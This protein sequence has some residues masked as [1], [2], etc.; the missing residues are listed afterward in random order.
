[1]NGGSFPPKLT[2]DLRFTRIYLSARKEIHEAPRPRCAP[3]C[4]RGTTACA[5]EQSYVGWVKR[6]VLFHGKR[7]P[8]EMGEAEIN[9]FLSSLATDG[10]VAASTQNQA[11]SAL[12][13]PLPPR[14]R[15]ALPRDAGPRPR[16]RPA[17]LPVVLTRDEVRRVLAHLGGE[18]APRRDAPLRLRPA[19]HG[20]APP[21]RQG[22]RPLAQRDPRAR[23]QGPEGPRHHAPDRRS[24]PTSPPTSR[25]CAPSTSAD[26]RARRRRR[27]PARRRPHQV[28]RR[29]RRA[30]PGSTSS[31]RSARAPTR[32]AARCAATTCPRRTSSAPSRGPSR[33]AGITKHASCHTLRHSFAT[34]LLEAGYDIRTIQELLG[35]RDVATTMIYTHVLN[36]GG[37]GVKSPLDAG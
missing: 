11:L 37:R 28:P 8:D 4:A 23:R 35:H 6:F 32:A 3:P 5:P 29:R 30:G 36:S 16:A 27:P 25:R 17:R 24:S 15:E 12:A 19:P 13:L 10:S 1:M 26:R 18:A 33:G 20:G 7:H 21:A 2:L 31:P 14:P 22:P 34:H 9:A